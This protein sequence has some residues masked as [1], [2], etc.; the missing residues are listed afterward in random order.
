VIETATEIK[1]FQLNFKGVSHN[2][3]FIGS[4]IPT[5][6]PTPAPETVDPQGN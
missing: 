1:N 4:M 3:L 2:P 5:P 6:T